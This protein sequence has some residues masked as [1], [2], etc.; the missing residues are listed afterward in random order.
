MDKFPSHERESAVALEPRVSA[1]VVVRN[2]RSVS[3]QH[4]LDLSLRAALAEPWIDDLVMVDAGNA[5]AVSSS[6]RALQMDRR[7]VKVVVAPSGASA[8]AA[9]NL[10]A[11]QARGRWFLFLAPSVVLQRGAAERLAAAGGSAKAPW[12]AGGRLTDAEGRERSAARRG[13]LNTWSAVAVALGWSGGRP[14]MRRGAIGRDDTPLPAEVGAV[15]GAFMLAPKNDFQSLG[16]FDEQFLT[17][18]ADLDLCRRARAAGGS[19]LFQPV[20]A[21]V[22]FVRPQMAGRKQAQGLALFAV[23]S[24]RTPFEKAFA[25]IAAPALSVIVTLRDFVVGRPPAR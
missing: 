8:G 20:A 10:G 9:A 6:L 21:G 19:V 23:R 24:A 12:I 11:E 17:D 3:A 4:A 25:I 16:G 22:Q 14:S 15:S 1:I 5:P 2:V 13:S 7:D 18:A